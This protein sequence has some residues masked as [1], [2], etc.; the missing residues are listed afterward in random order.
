MKPL[1]EYL[2]VAL[3]QARQKKRMSQRVLS[4]KVNMPQSHISKIESGK[5]DIKASSL[6]ELARTLDY[7]LML[8]PRQMVPAF[9]SLLRQYEQKE[10]EQIIRGVED[11]ESVT[12]VIRSGPQKPAYH[13]D[14]EEDG[15]A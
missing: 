13:L 5:V 1:I 15:D 9:Q 3:R 6:T 14:E 2:A 4:Q 8:V 10:S 11:N 7:E 12:A